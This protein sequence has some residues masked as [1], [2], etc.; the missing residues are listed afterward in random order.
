MPSISLLVITPSQRL[1][2]AVD[3]SST[4]GDVLAKLPRTDGLHGVTSNPRHHLGNR[5][6]SQGPRLLREEEI[7]S[8]IL[9]RSSDDIEV[10]L[11]DFSLLAPAAGPAGS[12]C[13]I[14]DP[15]K[16]GIT[17]EQLAKVERFVAPMAP[18]WCETLNCASLGQPLDFATVNHRHL[19][20]WVVH[21]ST[22]AIRGDGGHGCSFVELMAAKAEDQLPLW[23]LSFALRANFGRL[24]ACLGTHAQVRGLSLQVPYWNSLYA[25]NPH[26]LEDD[27]N[28]W[29]PHDLRDW[30]FYR[31]LCSA[32]GM[33]LVLDEEN[34]YF[35]ACWCVFELALV[36]ASRNSA[37][38]CLLDLGTALDG[39]S[40]ILT[41]GLAG[42]ELQMAPLGGMYL[43]ARREAGF[44]THHLRAGL[45]VDIRWADCAKES[46]KDMILNWIAFPKAS[47]KELRNMG[48]H[49]PT[50]HPNYHRVNRALFSHFALACWYAAEKDN[51]EHAREE[52]A[53]I[54]QADYYREVVELSFTGCSLFSDQQLH[55]LITHL[56]PALR[57]LRLDLAFTGLHTLHCLEAL[58]EMTT[59]VKL[60]LSFTGSR[61]LCNIDGL[62]LGLQGM[63]Q[64]REL[65]LC[66]LKLLQLVDISAL[67]LA[68]PCLNL[69]QLDLT[70]DSC[71][72][73]MPSS[74]LEIEKVAQRLKWRR[75]TRTSLTLQARAPDAQI[76]SFW[77][78]CGCASHGRKPMDH[79]DHYNLKSPEDLI[80]LLEEAD[81]RLVRGEFLLKLHQKSETMIRRQELE[82]QHGHIALVSQE[83]LRDWSAGRIK[84]QICSVSHCWESREH[85]D[86]FGYQLAI[87]A[88]HIHAADWF[89]IDY[90]SLY[91]YGRRTDEQYRCF[92]LAMKHMHVLYAHEFTST[93]RI[94]DLTPESFKERMASKMVTIYYEPTD[95]VQPVPITELKANATSYFDRGW[96]QAEVQ[97]SL[98][99]SLLAASYRIPQRPDHELTGRAPMAPKT[100][101]ERVEAKTFKFTHRSDLTDVLA[102][103]ESVFLEKAAACGELVVERLPA[104]EFPILATALPYYISLE[105]LVVQQSEMGW[106]GAK[107]LAEAIQESK[108][109]K[110]LTFAHNSICEDGFSCLAGALKTNLMLQWC[111]FEGQTIGARQQ[112]ALVEAQEMNPGLCVMY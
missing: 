13:R 98:S 67:V 45:G 12:I 9:E 108:T 16:R 58:R 72:R 4:V 33:L 95:S 41:E 36:V 69:S 7:L 106:D 107:A 44:P 19:Y 34:A 81:I 29:D 63:P 71:P 103:Q 21:P 93:L 40:S 49:A 78:V 53:R 73:L 61:N 59:I 38:A 54:L 100:F 25:Y 42:R 101:Q 8:E 92:Q 17:I 76:S 31:A 87:L 11:T 82:T 75:R 64:L 104:T 70:V 1:K 105:H 97:W 52:Y 20:T 94:E 110:T 5:L 39:H 99:R 62:G 6:L 96:C 109:L 23:F 35:K 102:L 2:L 55:N 91:Q 28:H 77:P 47:R 56:P 60:S 83:E 74:V 68:L 46:D 27:F 43:K 24:V 48:D 65:E 3:A 30:P 18:L 66:F 111:C 51:D 88:A 10:T 22:R 84:P 50:D 112:A 37:K 26:S 89:F 90:M 14:P 80:A 15:A 85:P 86:P 79:M 57:V 32:K